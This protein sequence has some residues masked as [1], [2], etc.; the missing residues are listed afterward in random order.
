MLVLVKQDKEEEEEYCSIK[1]WSMATHF[2]ST[3]LVH[4]SSMYSKWKQGAVVV[5]LTSFYLLALFI[6][7]FGHLQLVLPHPM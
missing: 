7:K 2:V 5:V 4:P 6:G 1:A 3:S